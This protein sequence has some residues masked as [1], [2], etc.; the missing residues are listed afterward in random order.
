MSDRHEPRARQRGAALVV[1]MVLLIAITLVSTTAVST[2]TM[3]LRI[4]GNLESS[5]DAFQTAM[6]AVDFTLSDPANLPT[7]GPLNVPTSVGL[8]GSPFAVA[9]ADVV[10]ASATRVADCAPPPRMTNATS[11]TA[12]A[13]FY[14]KVDASVDR[15]DTGMGHSGITQGYLL[16]GPKC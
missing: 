15:S 5:Y 2:S 13:G 16:L 1:A 8:S 11:M 6:A 12:Y 14:Y 4:A 3:E 10:A 7:V 9:G